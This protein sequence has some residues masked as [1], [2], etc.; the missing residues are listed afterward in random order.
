MAGLQRTA[1]KTSNVIVRLAEAA[2]QWHHRDI[3]A[4]FGKWAEGYIILSGTWCEPITLEL[5]REL[6]GRL[7][8]VHRARR[9]CGGEQAAVCG[10]SSGP[11]QPC[12]N[13]NAPAFPATDAA[14]HS[15]SGICPGSG[16]PCG[17]HATCPGT[18]GAHSPAAH[19][20]RTPAS[21]TGGPAP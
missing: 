12:G 20:L 5:L 1:A 11:S 16:E 7:A 8:A 6:N 19:D 18:G 4:T 14:N 21:M 13:Q 15:P 3:P 17:S 10:A 9:G 2:P